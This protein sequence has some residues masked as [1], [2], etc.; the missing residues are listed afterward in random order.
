MGGA[1]DL[2]WSTI[3]GELASL[4]GFATFVV[5]ILLGD[6]L[7]P[8]ALGNTGALVAG[9]L[10]FSIMLWCAFVVVRHAECLAT[11]LGEPYGTLILTISVIG[12]EV[13]LIASVMLAGSD[14]PTLARDTMMSVIM[15]VLNGLVGLSLVLGGLRHRMQAYNLQGANAF[16]SVLIPLAVVGLMLPRF[17]S[18]APGGELSDLHAVF[19]IVMSVA[20]YGV[21]LAI[22]TVSH[23]DIFRQPQTDA[24]LLAGADAEHDEHHHALEVRSVPFHAAALL[25]AL[26][27]IV[28]L[29]K[30]LAAYVDFGID[31][32]GAPLALGGFL[33]AALIL[34]PEGLTAIHAARVNQL[35][36]AVNICLGSAL[37]TIGLTIP[38]VLAIGWI[39]D[40][41]IELGLGPVDMIM[42]ALTLIVSLVT[43]ISARTN[44]LQGAVHL[45]IFAG[46][47]VLIFDNAP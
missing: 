10:L 22:Q 1:M 11:L 26:L 7:S 27:P 46:Y 5:V 36:R 19:L 13:A 15:I 17:T 20:L 23:S 3:R 44:A 42:L 28:L 30:K 37:A 35:Q 16:L 40:E 34:T 25:G 6:L 38:V 29:S 33:V 12:I 45:A 21:F 31:T 8:A 24:P 14:K 47:V 4:V 39:I 18:S 41:R 43:F 2:G 32:L 9:A